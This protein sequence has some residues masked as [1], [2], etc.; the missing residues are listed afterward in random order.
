MALRSSLLK[1]AI[2]ATSLSI[3][4]LTLSSI[5]PFPSG[6]FKVDLPSPNEVRWSYLNGVVTVTAPYSVDNGGIYDV[7]DLTVFY[8]V[9]NTTGEVIAS[10]RS[11]SVFLPAGQVTTSTLE[12]TIDVLDLY[13]R[14]F[15]RMVFDFDYLYFYVEVSCHYTM[16]LV[17]FD[18]DYHVDVLWDPLIRSWD[19][20]DVTPWPPTSGQVSIPYWLN[21]SRLL[22]GLPPASATF[23]L[24]GIDA[25]NARTQLSTTT[26]A[27][28]LGTDYNGAVTITV[29]SLIPLYDRYEIVYSATV[30]D[31]GIPPTTIN[32]PGWTP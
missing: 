11:E 30:A 9:T 31:F 25:S 10:H 23:T 20:G 18:A 4:A 13:R 26:A 6:Q 2:A 24:F 14:N 3:V 21:T 32:L 16:R 15:T 27:I 1:L 29:P 28:Q 22:S 5:W 7:D 17:K 19:V 8:R 12:F